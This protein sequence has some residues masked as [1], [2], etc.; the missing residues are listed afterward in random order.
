MAVIFNITHDGG[1]LTEYD[2][3]A[4]DAGDLSATQAAALAGTAYGLQCVIDDTNALY[5]D[6]NISAPSTEI[7]IRFYIDPN[8]LTMAN[9]DA[10][11]ILTIKTTNA[12]YY[13]ALVNVSYDGSNYEI[14]LT[15]QEDDGTDHATANYDISDAEHYVEIHI[16]RSATV[17]TADLWIDGAHKEQI[18][19]LDNYDLMADVS[20]IRFGPQTG[21]DA[22]TSGTLYLDELK[23]NDDGSEIGPITSGAA[24][25]MI[26]HKRRR[27]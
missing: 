21:L 15:A 11:R 4:T 22:G 20:K 9:G 5:G 8:S 3:T 2:A 24:V 23:G 16:V 1:D 27:V 19:S 13:A 18:T 14:S 17:G 6:K 25:Q 10:F 26:D 7:R 12:P